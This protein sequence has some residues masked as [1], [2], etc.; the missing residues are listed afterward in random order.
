MVFDDMLYEASDDLANPRR[1]PNPGMLVEAAEKHNVDL[2]KSLM[3]GDM[4][5]DR[6]AARRAGVNYLDVTE[7]FKR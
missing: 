6:E 5:T 3:I 7:V 1:K 2:G 4:D